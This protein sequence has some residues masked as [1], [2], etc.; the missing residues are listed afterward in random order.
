MLLL[1]TKKDLKTK[2]ANSI[3]KQLVFE[4]IWQNFGASVK[5][6]ISDQR[7]SRR[8]GTISLCL[9]GLFE[10]ILYRISDIR[11]SSHDT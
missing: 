11:K 2:S 8:K 7:F 1:H 4:K 10:D 3:K 9:R 6:R 5:Y